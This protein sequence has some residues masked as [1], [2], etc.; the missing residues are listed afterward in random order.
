MIGSH[1]HASPVKNVT[2]EAIIGAVN[3]TSSNICGQNQLA[4]EENLCFR[5]CDSHRPRFHFEA[6]RACIPI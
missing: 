3:A 6:V 2:V 4:R 1:F 5:I